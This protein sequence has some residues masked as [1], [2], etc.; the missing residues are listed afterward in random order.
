MRCVIG[1]WFAEDGM[2][3]HIARTE[4]RQCCGTKTEASGLQSLPP[5]CIRTETQ[6]AVLLRLNS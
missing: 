5:H 1:K 4:K 3:R 2:L 6:I